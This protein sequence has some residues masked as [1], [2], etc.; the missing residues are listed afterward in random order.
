MDGPS[1][2]GVD[3]STDG[4]DVAVLPSGESW[5]FTFT[6]A[7]IG[8]LLRQLSAL[9]VSL[10]C[11]ESTGGYEQK[12]ATVLH[13]AGFAV[14][15]VNP[16]C[17]RRFADAADNLAKTDALGARVIAHYAE[18]MN[19]PRWQRPDPTLSEIRELATRRDQLMG[20]RG[21]EKN[22]LYRAVDARVR[23]EIGLSIRWLEQRRPFLPI[24]LP[25]ET[26]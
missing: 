7:G 13:D 22:R 5:R 8:K 18:V 10:V 14:A 6:A 26:T 17:M 24:P 25:H 15:V 3:V 16:R 23:K 12:L 11:M 20:Q 21:R 1:F 4:F 2:N 19:P 9:T